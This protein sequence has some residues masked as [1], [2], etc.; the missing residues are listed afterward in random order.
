MSTYYYPFIPTSSAKHQA[1][2]AQT[3]AGPA[4]ST[5]FVEVPAE[6]PR[7]GSLGESLYPSNRLSSTTRHIQDL[8]ESDSDI[9][10]PPPPSYSRGHTS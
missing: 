9:N 7:R 4:A 3:V 2:I 5:G 8:T 1:R 6:G 10:N